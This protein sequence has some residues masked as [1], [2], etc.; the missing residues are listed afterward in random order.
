MV[1]AGKVI[2]ILAR[3]PIEELKLFPKEEVEITEELKFIPKEEVE[4]TEGR[5]E[6][7]VFQGV[8]EGQLIT[9]THAIFKVKLCAAMNATAPCILLQT[10]HI[11]KER[12]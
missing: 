1:V 7:E 2:L 11:R 6:E 5:A 3:G 4:I 9:E 8:Q 10:A 12:V